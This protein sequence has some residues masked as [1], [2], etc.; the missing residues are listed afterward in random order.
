M[1]TCFGSGVSGRVVYL[2][3]EA[4][5]DLRD[6]LDEPRILR[7]VSER[8]SQLGDRNIERVIADYSVIP[9]VF[10]NTLAGHGLP[11]SLDKV[12]QDLHGPGLQ[13]EGSIMLADLVGGGVNGPIA[14]A[15]R[16][17]QRWLT[18]R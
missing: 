12:Q 8:L 14:D 10:L 15:K 5:A 4:V 6:G 2:P 7:I 17:C 1:A 16:I 11:R 18:S 13:L 9:D 3:N